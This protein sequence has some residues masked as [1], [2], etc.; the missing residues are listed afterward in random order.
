MSK[1]ELMEIPEIDIESLD[2][3]GVNGNLQSH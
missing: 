2:E 1:H 3:G